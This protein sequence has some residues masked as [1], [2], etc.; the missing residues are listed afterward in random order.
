[1]HASR[2]EN[3]RFLVEQLLRPMVNLYTVSTLGPDGKSPG[4]TVAF[5]RQKRM[6]LKEDLRF[7]ADDSETEELFRLKARRVVEIGGRY[8]VAL[9]SGERI[10]TLEKR[11]KQSLIRSTWTILDASED[12]IAWARER[13]AAIA[14][15][16]RIK[17]LVPYGETIPIPYHFTFL[18]GEREIGELTRVLG[19]RDNYIL[20]L[21]PDAERALDRRLAI[22]LAIGLDAFQAR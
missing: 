13:S 9:P 16:R 8:D 14:I 12:Q 7:F 5:T 20:D 10:G 17:D 6:A 2:F 11:F 4:E 1:M 3:D 15:V 19:V 21:S 22:A 18:R